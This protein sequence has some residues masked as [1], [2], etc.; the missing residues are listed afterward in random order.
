MRMLGCIRLFCAMGLL[1]KQ[2]LLSVREVL[3]ARELL[4]KLVLKFQKSQ[5]YH[6]FSILKEIMC[7]AMISRLNGG[8]DSYLIIRLKMI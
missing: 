4:S 2:G 1:L 5:G 8:M 7:L 6:C 3:Y